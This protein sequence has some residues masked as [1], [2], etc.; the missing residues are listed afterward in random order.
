ME[1]DKVLVSL[2]P[3]IRINKPVDIGLF[4]I[5]ER[6]RTSNN[7]RDEIRELRELRNKDEKAYK[8]RKRNLPAVTA[9][10]TF[11][12]RKASGLKSYNGYI[13]ID[14][15]G[16]DNP[17]IS[18]FPQ[19]R[20]ELSKIKNIDA[21]FLSASGE[22]VFCFVKVGDDPQLHKQYFNA[23][24]VCF[25]ELGIKVDEKCS[26]I[27]RLRFVTFDENGYINDKDSVAF[28]QVLSQKPT[29]HNAR[30]EPNLKSTGISQKLSGPQNVVSRVEQTIQKLEAQSIDITDDYSDWIRIGFAFAREFGEEG[31]E[32]FHRVSSI[33]SK[34]DARQADS[35]Y[36]G[37]L[38]SDEPSNPATLGT[39]F[40]LVQ[41]AGV[42]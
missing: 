8:E 11:S 17:H 13:C 12:E 35:V 27:S 33:S 15:D 24:S 42:R 9:S 25:N 37:L 19:L 36:D 31:R 6:M 23:L 38:Q 10:G 32:L 20:D 22:G 2:Y 29:T 26:D 18:D 4:F 7:L 21:C 30:K 34:Y 16:Q 41:Q 28:T 39:F 5:L 1:K 3:N 14:I 40:Y